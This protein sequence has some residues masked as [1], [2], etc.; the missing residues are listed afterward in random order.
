MSNWTPPQYNLRVDEW[1][2]PNT[3]ALGPPDRT[4]LECQLFTDTRMGG[5][6]QINTSPIDYYYYEPAILFR[7][8]D[9]LTRARGTIHNLGPG[10]TNYYRMKNSYI[11]H[12]GFPNE[13]VADLHA[14]CNAD[15]SMPETY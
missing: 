5:I 2:P 4:G 11:M 13:Y 8:P 3:P 12:P 9:V 10:S 6:E 7:H 14:Q 1:I 15:G